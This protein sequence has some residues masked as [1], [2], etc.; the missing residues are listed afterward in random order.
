[1]DKIKVG[2]STCLLGEKVRFDGGHKLDRWLRDTLGSY[3]EYVPVC[4]EVEMGLPI[5]RPALRLVGG[6]PEEAR[7]V[8]SKTGEDITEQMETWAQKKVDELAKEDLCGF[9]FKAKSPSSGM[10]RVRLYNDS[11]MPNRAGVGMFARIFMERL[12][13][14][15]VEEDGRMHDPKL[16]ETFI[17]CIFTFKRWREALA[18]GTDNALADFHTRHKLLL[19]SHCPETYAELGPMVAEMKSLGR[20]AFIEGYQAGLMKALRVKTNVAKHLNV[21]QHMLG[22]FKKNLSA[23]EKQEALELFD[24]YRDNLVPLLVPLTLINHFVRKYDEPY[25]KDQYYLNPHPLEL[26][27]RVQL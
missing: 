12:P 16:K 27:L 7:L 20:E 3:V 23:D 4:P 26:K 8:V 15:P 11:G 1:M 19:L 24:Q 2:I 21:L 22:Y 14:I 5:P 18:A 17:E 25:L 6:T 10:E 13:L 9:I